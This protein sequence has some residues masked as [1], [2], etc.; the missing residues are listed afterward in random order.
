MNIPILTLDF[1]SEL[2]LLILPRENPILQRRSLTHLESLLNRKSQPLH[3]L[4]SAQLGD[5]LSHLWAT[6]VKT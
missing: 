3:K 2:K 5:N 6:C 1:R 4:Y